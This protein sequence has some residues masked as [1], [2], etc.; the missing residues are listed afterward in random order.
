MIFENVLSNIDKGKIG[1]NIG[2]NIGLPN[3][4]EYIPNLQKENLYLI[5]GETSTGK[6]AFVYNHFLYHP[7]EDWYKNHKETINF[8]VFVWSMEMSK[9]IVITKAI[10]RK[11]FLDYKILVD[12]NYILSRGK[13]RINDEIYNLVLQ[14]RKYFEE[15]ED[16][17]IILPAENPTGVQKLLLKY[18]NNNGKIITKILKIK[19][20]DGN[21][22]TIE[23][24]DRYDSN[25]PDQYI[26]AII[27]H[28]ALLKKERG[29][30]KKEVMDKMTEYLID[31][32]NNFK[33]IPVLVQQL[34]R[35]LSS[36]ER[37]RQGRISPQ[38]SDFKETSDSTDA[39]NYVLALF[40]PMRYDL[41]EYKGYNIERLK[42]RFRMLS[43]LK[44]RDGVT[45]VCK[46]LAF[47]GEIGM[48][49]EM[50]KSSDITEDHY[51]QLENIKKYEGT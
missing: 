49:K 8:K 39:A 15:L 47:L 9:D 20:K 16:R 35:D 17:V 33:I 42:N 34:N 26:V 6:S 37:F 10:C 48:F 23:V 32:R 21:E 12:V 28:L 18:L 43:I 7:Y 3:A 11:I 50:P 44:S 5:G 14:T 46:G 30:S 41:T 51:K 45:D 24:F 40:S 2:L 25:H 1:E 22:E 36:T 13:N 38:L 4:I 31:L 19:N 27:D 29:F